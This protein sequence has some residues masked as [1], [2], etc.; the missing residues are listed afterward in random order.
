MASAGDE[1]VS[2]DEEH[3]VH[4]NEENVAGGIFRARQE[5]VLVPAG[6]QIRCGRSRPR[7]IW[8]A[9]S[10]RDQVIVGGIQTQNPGVGCADQQENKNHVMS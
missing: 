9:D 7:R 3:L 2:D 4:H 6:A 5:T 10:I 8:F 1:L